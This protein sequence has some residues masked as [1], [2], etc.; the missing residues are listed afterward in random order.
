MVTLA[1]L[2]I[3]SLSAANP[4]RDQVEAKDNLAHVRAVAEMVVPLAVPAA[5]AGSSI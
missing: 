2:A 3:G 5:S 1:T 4:K